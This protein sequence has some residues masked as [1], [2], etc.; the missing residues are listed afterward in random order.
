MEKKNEPRCDGAV[1][2]TKHNLE[3]INTQRHKKVL[4]QVGVVM[5]EVHGQKL[6]LE[7]L[8]DVKAD[9]RWLNRTGRNKRNGKS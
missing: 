3:I 8:E 6:K 4:I 9:L 2:T 7:L 1:W 5:K